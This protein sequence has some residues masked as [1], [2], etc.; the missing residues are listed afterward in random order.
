MITYSSAD[1]NVF[2]LATKSYSFGNEFFIHSR[3]KSGGFSKGV[4]LA[5]KT[6]PF[7]VQK[8]SF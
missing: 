5:F 7:G 4:L 8:E 6:S 3:M 2:I 1:D